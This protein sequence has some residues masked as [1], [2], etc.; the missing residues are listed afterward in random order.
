MTV[1][2]L[3]RLRAALDPGRTVW[4]WPKSDNARI[5]NQRFARVERP[6][7]ARPFAVARPRT[8]PLANALRRTYRETK[9]AMGEAA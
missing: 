5:F 2:A 9:V 6:V 7:V 4:D 3:A 1:L 8:S